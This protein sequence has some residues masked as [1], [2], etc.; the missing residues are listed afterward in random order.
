MNTSD[1]IPNLFQLTLRVGLPVE[2]ASQTIYYKQVEL[3]EITLADER[4]AVQV[5]ERVV[6]WNGAPKLVVSDSDHRLALTLRHIKKFYIPGVGE[7]ETDIINFDLAGKL[8]PVDVASLE[9]RVFLIELAQK[10]RYGE[11]SQEKFDAF[12]KGTQAPEG[13]LSAPQ[14]VGPAAAAGEPG[15]AASSGPVMLA[16]FAGDRSAGAGDGASARA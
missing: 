12:L 13:G 16:D 4:W 5:S 3:R 10:V 7:I 1:P 11:I 2:R 15:A 14:P 8:L 6:Q 9:E